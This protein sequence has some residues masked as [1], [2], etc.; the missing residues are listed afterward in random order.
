MVDTF[1]CEDRSRIMSRVKGKHT[2][3]EV[4]I[5]KVLYS[6]GYRFRLHSKVLPGKPD[7]I[8]NKYK[9]VIFLNGCLWHGH[10][11]HNCRYPT[12]NTLYWRTKI[13]NN[14]TRDV[15]NHQA[16]LDLRFRVL[17]V[18]GCALSGKFRIPKDELMSLI[19]QWI[20]S[21]NERYKSIQGIQRI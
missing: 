1:S 21:P 19:N 7:I 6:C 2:S 15:K 11:C 20:I 18:W 4:S 13:Q 16:I 17:V 10:E 14:K 12:T 9:C 3:I 5:R 8:L